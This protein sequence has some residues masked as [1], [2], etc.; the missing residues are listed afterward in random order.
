METTKPPPQPPISNQPYQK[1]MMDTL[2]IAVFISSRIAQAI[3]DLSVRAKKTTLRYKGKQIIMFDE[4]AIGMNLS[5]R[6]LQRYRA[7]G[8]IKYYVSNDGH[9]TFTTQEQFDDFIERNFV[10][11][12]DPRAA[13]IRSNCKPNAHKGR[14]PTK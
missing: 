12:D 14:K 3:A 2:G 13:E 7:E 10:A 11:S 6:T 9:T 8:K 5:T 1:W 4:F